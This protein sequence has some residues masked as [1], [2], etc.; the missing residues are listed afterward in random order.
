M[1][2]GHI[3]D[4]FRIILSDYVYQVFSIRGQFTYRT[5]TLM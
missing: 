2:F 5:R 4:K 3:R 1:S